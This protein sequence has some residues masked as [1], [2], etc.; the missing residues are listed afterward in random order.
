MTPKW[1]KE[2]FEVKVKRSF[3]KRK[4]R[5]AEKQKTVIERKRT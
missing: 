2:E 1:K 4:E 5:N 3:A